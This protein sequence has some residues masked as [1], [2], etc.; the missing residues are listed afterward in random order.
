MTE[1]HSKQNR[2]A[3]TP[4]ARRTPPEGGKAY[5]GAEDT[6][7]AFDCWCGGPFGHDW[8]G[9]DEGA[10]HPRNME[11]L[12][13]TEMTVNELARN[14]IRSFKKKT[15]DLLLEI[16]ND[17]GIRH[18]IID[19]SHIMLYPPDRDARPFKVSA[20]RSIQE[21]ERI[22]RVQ[23]M[24][25]YGL[26]PEEEETV[27]IPTGGEVVE[28]VVE[29]EAL[30]DN[31]TAGVT[32]EFSGPDSTDT[33]RKVIDML[34]TVIGSESLEEEALEA[35]EENDRLA[36]EV[37]GLKGD[38]DRTKSLH[39]ASEQEVHR[40]TA[41]NRRLSGLLDEAV[42]RATKYEKKWRVLREAF[43]DDE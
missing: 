36:R 9:K 5:V 10:P 34:S 14:H 25:A 3:G 41:E 33:I 38:F 18:R 8:P 27:E 21:N 24:Q 43:A 11:G 31:D 32:R 42:A 23:F 12:E 1:R 37:R 29:P 2:F 40:L 17:Y 16:V 35:L 6:I 20:A 28:P 26:V 22:L 15:Q 39:A 13:V 7:A 4:R 30:S 19:G